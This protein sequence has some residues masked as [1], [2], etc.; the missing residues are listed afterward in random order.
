[1]DHQRQR[2]L[3]EPGIEALA[4]QLGRR[5]VADRQRIIQK[6]PAEAARAGVKEEAGIEIEIAPPV[7]VRPAGIEA[8]GKFQ[9]EAVVKR[10]PDLGRAGAVERGVR[11]GRLAAQ[12]GAGPLEIEGHRHR[13]VQ[14]Q[15]VGVEEDEGLAL[16]Q[17]QQRLDLVALRIGLAEGAALEGQDLGIEPRQRA[18][19]LAV[20]DRRVAR[21]ERPRLRHRDD[22]TAGKAGRR[23]AQR[24]RE[25]QRLELQPPGLAD[26]H[27]VESWARSV[28]LCHARVLLRAVC[29]GLASAGSIGGSGRPVTAQIGD[30]A[31]ARRA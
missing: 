30:G 4:G 29:R 5:V 27:D 12:R 24:G 3:V 17:G 2:H 14:D 26:D 6:T 16:G 25:E 21:P 15:R 10:L 23:M 22:Q 8:G 7:P 18:Q 11:P 20:A 31:C 19:H 28:C 13:I 9:P 1:M